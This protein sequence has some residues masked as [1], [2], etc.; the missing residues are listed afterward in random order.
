M[1]LKLICSSLLLISGSLFAQKS[2]VVI[3]K[4]VAQVGDEIIL[5]S[6]IQTEKLQMIQSS[7]E[8]GEG[9]QTDCQILEGLM[10]ENLLLNQAMLD[11]IVLPE[12]QADQE[13][14]SRLRVIEQQIGGRE[15][16]EKFYGKSVNQIKDEFREVIR[17]KLL[18]QEV[19][20]TITE[21]LNVTPKEVKVFFDK[22]PAD[23][24]PFINAS[25]GLQQIIIYPEITEADKK[26]AYDQLEQI[27][28]EIIE[29]GKSF[30]TQ[31]RIYSMDPGSA[32][33]GGKLEAT[34]GMMVPQFESMAFSLKEG[35][36]SKVFETDY[37]YH[38]IKLNERRGDDYKC[39]HILIMPEFNNA[40]LEKAAMR[41]DSCYNLMKEGKITWNDAVLKYSN[42]EET[43]QNNGVI[44]D[45]RTGEPAWSTEKLNE[46]DQQIYILT[47]T[48][49]VGEYSQPSL[50]ANIFDGRQGVRIV[51]I[52]S[53]TD[54]HKAN[55]TQDYA[56]IKRAAEN[57]KRERI[58]REWTQ[59]KISNAYINLDNEYKDCVFQNTWIAK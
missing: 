30:D 59:D 49:K 8:L 19:E 13:M 4:I 53:K 41:I 43:K 16:L 45:P 42:D 22:I 51:R 17:K 26:K 11:S 32:K 34:R 18:T 50:Y 9:N 1:T 15:K 44:V 27:R 33:D 38:I 37:G 31:A 52:M 10:Y 2:P 3:D 40:E 56:L 25:L 47:N 6:D 20:R 24:V 36:I 54:Q 39:Q 12:G 14:E 57:E 58:L 23:S 35:E 21:G 7:I 55:L 5:L 46:I 29:S 28:K 48:L